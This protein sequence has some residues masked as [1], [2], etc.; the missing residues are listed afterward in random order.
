M[1]PRPAGVG[2]R[3]LDPA[4]WHP[5]GW[6]PRRTRFVALDIATGTS[7]ERVTRPATSREPI[8]LSVRLAV[9]YALAPVLALLIDNLTRRSSPAV[10][11]WVGE[12]PRGLLL[13]GDR[14]GPQPTP[15]TSPG[16]RSSS[17]SPRPSSPM[18]GRQYRA[19]RSSDEGRPE[20]L[21]HLAAPGAAPRLPRPPAA[22]HHPAP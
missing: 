17:S 1:A 7:W 13:D 14:D 19:S 5:R 21:Q 10:R 22:A 3:D 11:P 20:N 4:V 16:A 15:P 18:A 2:A 6:T 9:R 8:A 12:G